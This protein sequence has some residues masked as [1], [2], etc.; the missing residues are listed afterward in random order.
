M[1]VWNKEN[2]KSVINAF[3]EVKVLIILG[4]FRDNPCQFDIVNVCF[5]NFKPLIKTE[6]VNCWKENVILSS[7]YSNEK[8]NLLSY[9]FTFCNDTD[10]GHLR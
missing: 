6:T 4:I 3:T 1:S 5:N 10:F 7:F 2:K 9:N 8:D